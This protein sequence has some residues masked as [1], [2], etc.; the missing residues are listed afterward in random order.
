MTLLTIR[1]ALADDVTAMH[2][3]RLAV[4]ENRLSFPA[5]VSEADYH[6]RLLRGD[7]AWVAERAGEILGFAMLDGPSRSIWALF[8][9]PEAERQGVGRALQ[10]V[11][12]EAAFAV[13]PRVSLST[14]PGTR[15]ESF[16]RVSGWIPSGTRENGERAFELTRD[17]WLSRNN[18]QHEI[19]GGA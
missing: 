10:A 2:A 6:A 11:M 19:H 16:Y 9:S 5:R 15:A 12:L 1:T 4:R 7:G 17:A 13:W 14:S 8:V 3:I 18:F